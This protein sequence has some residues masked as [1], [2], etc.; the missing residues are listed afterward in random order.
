MRLRL[1]L[2]KLK[3]N[4]MWRAC[5]LAFSI[6]VILLFIL[7]SWS[8]SYFITPYLINWAGW[9]VTDYWAFV[10]VCIVALLLL[11][12]VIGILF[13]LARNKHLAFYQ[14]I[15]DAVKQIS[16]GDF[17]VKIKPHEDF[18]DEYGALVESINH[19]AG[20]LGQMERMRQE[21]ISNVSHEI[22]SPLTS[23]RGFARVLQNEE[24]TEDERQHYLY[25]IEMET[26]RLS[27]LSDNLLKLTSLESDHHPM[28]PVLFRLDSQIR[29]LILVS[30]PQWSAK[31][32][33]IDLNLAKVSIKADEEM[34]SQV[35]VNLIH[36]AIKFTP[37]N[38]S[39]RID[40]K[41]SDAYVE[42]VVQ[43]SGIGI[44]ADQLPHVFERFFKADVSRNRT[45][46]GNGLG[47]S[48]VQKIVQL[49]KGTIAVVS[50]R[51]VGSTF[52]VKLP[53]CMVDEGV[54]VVRN[55][56]PK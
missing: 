39:I 40:M 51:G 22:Q 12:A 1:R 49:H 2:K 37:D 29:K 19:M 38:G 43:D 56:P 36:N 3:A 8:I 47:L 55:S 35:W 31:E 50:T 53:L 32:L 41:K 54:P 20:E 6:M 44:K 10:L 17:D 15:V 30:E 14:S 28:E 45:Q 18:E 46:G 13:P 26:M 42:V 5:K 9:S 34:L 33:D 25:I 52:T 7:A 4:K 27:K 23:I 16:R 24:L 11:G 21:F 48:I